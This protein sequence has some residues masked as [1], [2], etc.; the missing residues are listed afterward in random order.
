MLM[1]NV[2]S[3]FYIPSCF[4]LYDTNNTHKHIDV[5]GSLD[6]DNYDYDNNDVLV[7]ERFHSTTDTL[8]LHANIIDDMILLNEQLTLDIII[9]MI[10]TRNKTTKKMNKRL[11]WTTRE[12]AI[13][14]MV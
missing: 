13:M 6:N 11:K 9:E 12:V 3:T 7:P 14:Q 10:T 5:D 4:L 2:E 8:T 1:L